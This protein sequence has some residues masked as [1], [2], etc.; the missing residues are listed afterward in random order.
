[1]G[2]RLAIND[3]FP[4]PPMHRHPPRIY[5]NPRS[6]GRLNLWCMGA[7]INHFV[8]IGAY[9]HAPYGLSIYRH[10]SRRNDHARSPWVA[11]NTQRPPA[12]LEQKRARWVLRRVQPPSPLERS[13]RLNNRWKATAT[14][15]VLF[16][17]Q[18]SARRY[19][20][21]DRDTF[22]P[23]DRR[24]RFPG[25]GQTDQPLGSTRPAHRPRS[26]L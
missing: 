13:P 2:E 10:R 17:D 19:D 12:A 7:R 15:D 4:S 11:H 20:D 25:I 3:D 23:C 1:M 26:P 24:G 9:S 6:L 21:N 5:D 14:L 22:E 8:T 18:K 16:K